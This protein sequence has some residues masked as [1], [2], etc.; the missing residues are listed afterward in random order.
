MPAG[1]A[2]CS[3]QAAPGPPVVVLPGASPMAC[4]AGSIFQAG[5]PSRH[6]AERSKQPQ[7]T[8]L[9]DLSYAA[10]HRD[11]AVRAHPSKRPSCCGG[12]DAGRSQS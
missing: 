9:I 10:L 2:G 12:G 3:P 6:R 4:W 7:H 8:I 11:R 1:S 5:I